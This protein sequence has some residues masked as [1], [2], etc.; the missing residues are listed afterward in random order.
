MAGDF[1]LIALV[2]LLVNFSALAVL[3]LKLALANGFQNNLDPALF[4][5]ALEFTFLQSLLSAL[6]SVAIGLIAAPGYSRLGRLQRP[7]RW[8][9]LFPSLM[10]Q[11]L[12]VLAL[13]LSFKNFPFGMKGIILGH[14][15]LNGGL[16][17]IWLGE[18]W[19]SLEER[20]AP[21]NFVLGG[22]TWQFF[23]KI[24][25][26]QMGGVILNTFAVIFS[27]CLSSFAI[28]LVFGGGPQASTI[29]VLIY[30]QLRVSGDLNSALILGLSQVC[31]QGLVYF[32]ILR[33][34]A[35]NISKPTRLLMKLQTRSPLILGPIAILLFSAFPILKIIEMALPQLKNISTL[36]ALRNFLPS[37]ENSLIVGVVLAAII[38]I[39]LPILTSEDLKPSFSRMPTLSGVVIGLSSFIML[40]ALGSDSRAKFLL[41]LLYGHFCVIFLAIK[42]LAAPKMNSLREQYGKVIS[43]LG[44]SQWAAITKVY[45]P[46]ERKFF[47][48]AA[49]LA[50]IWSVGEFSVS[51]ILSGEF[52]TLPVFIEGL[53]SSYR[54]ELA[55]GASLLLLGLTVVSLT[56]FEVLI[57]GLG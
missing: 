29:E 23:R 38:F 3:V 28:P 4:H 25:L 12:V 30:E 9:L 22:S 56:L 34:I 54:L 13:L 26:P 53:L 10:S 41:L 49:L 43:Q 55:A 47:L 51:R 50:G 36:F 33:T 31:I 19:Q 18:A 15:F 37:I 52:L 39:L 40:N 6:A 46:L 8:L 35:P 14:V 48:S 24:L 1:R 57:N 32:L 7:V 45:L 11:V 44:A 42:R 2:I 5:K 20:W 27:F 21:V 17:T 16:C